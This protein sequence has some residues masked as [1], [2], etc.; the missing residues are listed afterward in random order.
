MTLMSRTIEL[1]YYPISKIQTSTLRRLDGP[2]RSRCERRTG[3]AMGTS[4]NGQKWSTEDMTFSRHF[5]KQRKKCWNLEMIEIRYSTTWQIFQIEFTRSCW[6]TLKWAECRFKS[7]TIH[8]TQ[9][10]CTQAYS[11]GTI[12]EILRLL[13]PRSWLFTS[14]A[15]STCLSTLTHTSRGS[16]ADILHRWWGSF[17]AWKRYGMRLQDLAIFSSNWR[18][19]SRKNKVSKKRRC[20]KS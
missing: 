18:A 2:Y 14:Q 9:R 7:L 17:V 11:P 16:C 4:I 5:W 20:R 6:T 3:S 15:K 13:A 8:G 19:S 10:N 12:W 1:G